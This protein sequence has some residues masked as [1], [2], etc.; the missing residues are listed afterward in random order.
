MPPNKLARRRALNLLMIF[1]ISTGVALVNQT[2]CRMII[3]EPI[4]GWAVMILAAA[5]LAVIAALY[6][7]E[8]DKEE[9]HGTDDA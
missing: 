7:D 2:C 6:F 3:D 9:E 8:P 5:A 4:S 1:G